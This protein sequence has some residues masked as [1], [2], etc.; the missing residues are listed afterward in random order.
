MAKPATLPLFL[1]EDAPPTPQKAAT[2][3]M[4]QY[5]EI[6]A[7]YSDCLLFYRMGDFYELFFDDAIA[8][9]KT[10]DIALTTR[11]EH[12]GAPIPMCGVPF[13]AYENY[14]A[15]LIRGGHRVA[16]AEQ[17]ED[18]KEAKKR[19][20]KS[21]VQRDVVRVVTPGTITEETLL[22]A[23]TNNYLACLARDGQYWGAAWVD[24][25]TGDF[26]TENF[27]DDSL[28]AWLARCAP[29]EC[30]VQD[31][32]IA[33]ETLQ[34]WRDEKSGQITLQPASKFNLANNNARLCQF[35]KIASL[36]IY[37]NFSAAEII[38]AGA[39]LDYLQLTQ[40]NQ[41]PALLP[42][43]PESKN[44]SL[45]MDGSTRRNL[46]L[47]ETSRGERAGSL[48]VTIDKTITPM[49]AR[50]LAERISA[51]LTDAA[52]I[53]T[54][55]DGVEFALRNSELRKS[56]RALWANCPDFP[57]A[58]GR[59][60]VGRGTP[61][62]LG[63]LR[64]TLSVIAK[65]QVQ[66]S[67]NKDAPAVW[68]DAR[69][70]LGEF[71]ALADELGRA[72]ADEIPFHQREGDFIRAGY[73]LALDEY[74][75]LRSNGK[76]MMAKLQGKYIAET[77]ITN[78]KIKHNNLIGYHI[79]VNPQG[80]EKLLQQ[81]ETY[82][83]RQ[84]MVNAVRFTTHELI[85]LEQKMGSAEDRA[86][87]IELK[88]FDRLTEI[89]LQRYAELNLAAQAIAEMD[90]MSAL[91]ELAQSQRYVRPIID[92]SDSFNIIDGRHA[93]VEQFA[94]RQNFVP[95]DCDLSA[96]QKIW[97]LTG[98]NMAGKSTF[99]RQNALIVILAQ[100]GGYVPAKSA[101]I[102]TVDRLFS[103]VGAGDD[104]ARGRSTFMVEMLETAT[105]LQQA[106]PRSFVIFDELGR[107]TATYDGLSIAWAVLE[108]LHEKIKCRTLFAT[109]YHELTA[110][111]DKL[112]ALSC[113]TVTVVEKG[114]Q[115]TFTHQVA[116]GTADRSYGVHV[117]EIAGIPAEVITRA[118]ALLEQFENQKPA[119]NSN[120]TAPAPRPVADHP[121]V[122][123]LKK[124]DTDNLT[125]KD[126]LDILYRLSELA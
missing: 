100:M 86:L 45:Q 39:L 19:G 38:A 4:A 108:H 64:T 3:M 97:L 31:K 12:E 91:A 17:M 62:D 59:L 26:H 81:K 79:E 68:T 21:V 70:N 51:P 124:L 41:L 30:L 109:H 89:V 69:K 63:A 87:A 90:V 61:R 122:A 50:M 42:L 16:I 88:L 126:A 72:L 2:P 34:N 74:R 60:S 112:A 24:M 94:A 83:H 113:F 33:Y 56:L 49:G 52:A 32:E 13:H 7:Q 99:L 36:E 55:L 66:L 98:P 54:R 5:L 104:L 115:I 44:H 114:S 101:H 107:G 25:S 103:R 75:G 119:A 93:I 37:G 73:D 102:G 105:I 76:Q 120:R 48:L 29:S 84:T 118:N 96:Q 27:A 53:N 40:K 65:M 47:L 43:R 15:K 110:L 28:S 9:A 82:I 71:S 111:A 10:L 23:R 46:E 22:N 85:E 78:L 80:G 117:A 121:A 6:K 67:A 106:T 35:F 58:L 8:A 1:N 95:N 116:P 123:A 14:L 92:D 11:G 125:P 18:P 57:R 20:A 77:G